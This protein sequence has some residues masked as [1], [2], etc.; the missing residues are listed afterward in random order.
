MGTRSRAEELSDEVEEESVGGN[1]EEYVE[2]VDAP[3]N[4]DDSPTDLERT[5]NLNSEESEVGPDKT[6][7]EEEGSEENCGT[8]GNGFYKNSY[9]CIECDR[10]RR[11]FHTTCE[12]V[13]DQQYLFYNK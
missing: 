12:G 6:D 3:I 5:V 9:K 7:I 8:C 4:E 13:S 2:I 10:C 11:W 1:E